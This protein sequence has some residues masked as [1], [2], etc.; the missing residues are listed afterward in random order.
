MKFGY[1]GG[2][3]EKELFSSI[4]QKES[5]PPL[6][7]YIGYKAAKNIVK[8]SQPYE[9]PSDPDPRFANDLHATVAESLKLEDYSK[10]RLFTAVDSH[11]DQRHQVDAF[12]ELDSRGGRVVV[13]LDV[14]T[15]P[16]KGEYNSDKGILVFLFPREGLDPSLEEDKEEYFEIIEKL[17]NRIVEDI[18]NKIKG[19]NYEH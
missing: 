17:N 12:F 14:T 3:L 7:L 1:T 4:E 5:H 13:K 19:K 10:L 2:Q 18:E 6:E 11:F 8:D 9:D 15:N 16:Q